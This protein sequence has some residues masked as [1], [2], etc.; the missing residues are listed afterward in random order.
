MGQGAPRNRANSIAR[1]Y[2][3]DTICQELFNKWRRIF[4]FAPPDRTVCRRLEHYSGHILAGWLLLP[5]GADWIYA[6]GAMGWDEAGEEGGCQQDGDHDG[7]RRE[8][9]GPHA[10]HQ[11][12]Q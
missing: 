3:I 12:L 8:V 11:A 6:A 7:E 4:C 5:E 2:H 9:G 10:I 1:V